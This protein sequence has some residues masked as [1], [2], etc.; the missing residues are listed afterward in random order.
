MRWHCS[1]CSNGPKEDM[2]ILLPAHR[3]FPAILIDRLPWTP[4][5]HQAV[6]RLRRPHFSTEVLSLSLRTIP[7][8]LKIILDTRTRQSILCHS[9]ILIY[10]ILTQQRL[11]THGELVNKHHRINF[12]FGW[13]ITVWEELYSR[14]MAWMLSS[15]PP[16][17]CQWLL[18][19][20]SGNNH[21]VSWFVCCCFLNSRS[22]LLYLSVLWAG[23]NMYANSYPFIK[24]KKIYA[25]LIT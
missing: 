10:H 19:L 3:K 14:S 1:W 23:I 5:P 8:H 12:L 11:T 7:S 18:L 4:T 6:F 25:P 9:T 17:T 20:K 2:Q 15:C 16:N 22:F 24:I 21:I 13:P